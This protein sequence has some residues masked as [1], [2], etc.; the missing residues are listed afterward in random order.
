MDFRRLGLGRFLNDLGIIIALFSIFIEP[1]ILGF[2]FGIPFGLI[3]IVFGMTGAF[4]GDF[5]RGLLTITLAFVLTMI[6]LVIAI[7][8]SLYPIQEIVILV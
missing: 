2:P 4:L 3:A 1:K 5:K 6:E 7:L 8:H